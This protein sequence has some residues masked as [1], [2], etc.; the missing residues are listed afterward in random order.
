MKS[1]I[2][3]A[4]TAVLLLTPVAALAQGDSSYGHTG[5]PIGGWYPHYLYPRY[6][7]STAAEG[8][9]R[10]M[11]MHIWAR[12]H[13]NYMTAQARVAAAHARQLEIDN[14]EQAANTYFSMREANRQ[15]RA[16]QRRPRTTPEQAARLA[17]AGQPDFLSPAEFDPQANRIAWLRVLQSA[18]FDRQRTRIEEILA[19]RASGGQ[20]ATDEAAQVEE[21]VQLM[22]TTLRGQIHELPP[23]EYISGRRFL[24][25]LAHSARQPFGYGPVGLAATGF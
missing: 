22:L 24:E 2:L 23:S 10:G 12:G 17:A 15:A 11:A 6:H 14:R 8:Y 9:L 19:S 5:N 18:E 20:L 3:K 13:Y 16:E 25:R 7:S 21:V 1:T 4:V